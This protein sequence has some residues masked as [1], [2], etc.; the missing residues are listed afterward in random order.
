MKRSLL[1][2]K[3]WIKFHEKLF[4][5]IF[6]VTFTA[7][8]EDKLY[9][10]VKS[11]SSQY[12]SKL[13]YIWSSQPKYYLVY[14]KLLKLIQVNLIQIKLEIKIK[15][16]ESGAEYLLCPVERWIYA[17]HHPTFIIPPPLCKSLSLG[18]NNPFHIIFV[19]T[20]KIISRLTQMTIPQLT[21][22]HFPLR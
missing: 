6:S 8:T 1:E 12:E 18:R 10:R 14:D 3:I 7:A 11:D 20:I 17:F 5:L 15:Q 16:S 22:M 21:A 13:F 2:G 4:L 9:Q 19:T